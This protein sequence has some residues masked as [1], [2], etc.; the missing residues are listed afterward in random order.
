M[1]GNLCH[2]DPV[3]IGRNA[4]SEGRMTA[5]PPTVVPASFGWLVRAGDWAR[6]CWRRDRSLRALAA[7]GDDQL[8]NLSE[9]GRRLRTEAQW[10]SD[11]AR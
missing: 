6:R 9:C 4:A 3:R 1:D 2:F 8:A 7:L 5:T 10:R 11:G